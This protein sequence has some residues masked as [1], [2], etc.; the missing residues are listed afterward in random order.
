MNLSELHFPRSMQE[1]IALMEKESAIQIIAGATTFGM[2]QRSRYL[3]FDP[4]IACIQ[5]IPELASIHK[6]ERVISIGSTCTLAT[7][8]RLY[9]F[10]RPQARALLRAIGTSAVRGV[11]TIGGHIMY[12]KRFLSLWPLLTCL[13]AE[14]E[15]RTPTK[16]SAKNIWYLAD[17]EGRPSIDRGALLTRIRIPLQSLDHLFIRKIGGEIFPEGDGAYLVSAASTDRR[18]LSNFKLVIA[19]E[20]AFRDYEAEQR[21]TSSPF[22][23][24]NKTMQ[25]VLRQYGESIRK[26]GYWNAEVLLPLIA[27]ALEDLQRTRA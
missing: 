3:S 25:A 10:D 19:G 9:P 13:D 8:E 2:A 15:F 12:P 24:S 18:S 22:P 6:T 23:L 16:T 1:F 27:Q 17:P 7:L 21:V 5:Y 4:S 20:R 26:R 14:V 11:A